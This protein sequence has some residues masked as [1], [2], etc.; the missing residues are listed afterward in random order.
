MHV[1]LHAVEVVSTVVRDTSKCDVATI[2]TVICAV[3]YG[4]PCKDCQLRVLMPRNYGTGREVDRTARLANPKADEINPDIRR[5]GVASD[6]VAGV[7]GGVDVELSG[8]RSIV[9]QSHVASQRHVLH[10]TDVV[11]HRQAVRAS[12]ASSDF[13]QIDR[14]TVSRALRVDRQPWLLVRAV[15]GRQDRQ[16]DVSSIGRAAADT[17]VNRRCGTICPV[18]VQRAGVSAAVWIGEADRSAVSTNSDSSINLE[19]RVVIAL[20]RQRVAVFAVVRIEVTADR[21]RTAGVAVGD[22]GHIAAETQRGGC[23]ID[24]DRTGLLVLSE[25]DVVEVVVDRLQ[26]RIRHVQ[27]N[28]SRVIAE[29]DAACGQVAGDVQIAA[30]GLHA[31][32]NPAKHNVIGGGQVDVLTIG[33]GRLQ[34]DPCS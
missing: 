24:I 32:G 26:R 4:V 6:D 13:R 1:D 3:G 14:S 7:A 9:T 29:I 12:P 2:G 31:V 34:V 10:G 27:C 33:V 23:R 22:E 11:I 16:V 15:D 17:R 28:A 20:E 21:D 25:G 30:V 19:R 18:N 5:R 8:I